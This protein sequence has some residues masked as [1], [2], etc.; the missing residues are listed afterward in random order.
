M[1]WVLLDVVLVASSAA[2]LVLSG[3]TLWRQL[4]RLGGDVAT[5]SGRFTELSRLVAAVDAPTASRSVR[6]G[7]VRRSRSGVR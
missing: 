5:A 4:K 1:L 2:L 7:Q 6:S 3:L